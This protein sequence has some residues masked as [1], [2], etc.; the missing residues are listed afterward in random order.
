MF[1]RFCAENRNS[2]C[3]LFVSLFKVSG[4]RCPSSLLFFCLYVI[5]HNNVGVGGGGV[6]RCTTLLGKGMCLS[7]FRQDDNWIRE[8]S[9]CMCT[10]Y[11]ISKEITIKRHLVW[12]QE[13]PARCVIAQWSTW[14][15]REWNTENRFWKINGSGWS[16][17]YDSGLERRNKKNMYSMIA[18]WFT[19][20]NFRSFRLDTSQWPWSR[21]S[22]Q[23]FGKLNRSRTTL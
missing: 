23:T 11:S 7:R 5:E 16:S 2:A 9:I 19:T 1:F 8:V 4:S 17:Q 6:H 18:Q 22:S 21:E 14:I 10:M 15:Q 20:Y 3:L 13:Y 12:K